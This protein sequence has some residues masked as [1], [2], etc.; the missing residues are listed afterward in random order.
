MLTQ[1]QATIELC[2]SMRLNTAYCLRMVKRYSVNARDFLYRL[3]RESDITARIQ[4]AH[5][6]I[7]AL[8]PH[9]A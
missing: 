2:S 6:F 8:T 1:E 9:T 4:V 5:D 3:D 7:K